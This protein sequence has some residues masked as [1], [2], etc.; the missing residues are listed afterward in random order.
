MVGCQPPQGP[1]TTSSQT[2]FASVQGWAWPSP[3]LPLFIWQME[4]KRGLGKNSP[5][6]WVLGGR[7]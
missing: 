3:P 5:S 4:R 2:S 1:H 6:S 7:M